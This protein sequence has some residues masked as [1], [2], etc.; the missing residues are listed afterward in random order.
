[1]LISKSACAVQFSGIEFHITSN[2]GNPLVDHLEQY[3][4]IGFIQCI[5]I[6]FEMNFLHEF[7]L[8]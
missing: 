4:F 6:S 5:V 2:A 1:M 8:G 3:N 7:H